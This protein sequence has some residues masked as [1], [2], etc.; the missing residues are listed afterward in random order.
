MVSYKETKQ[1]KVPARLAGY[2]DSKNPVRDLKIRVIA[3]RLKK[4]TS[5]LFRLTKS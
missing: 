4:R 3:D 5:V 1:S 2:A